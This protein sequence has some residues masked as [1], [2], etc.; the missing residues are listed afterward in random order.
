[1]RGLLKCLLSV[2]LAVVLVARPSAVAQWAV[3]QLPT[4]TG[5]DSSNAWDINDRGQV[6]GGSTDASGGYRAVLWD[7]HSTVIDLGTLPGG[8]DSVATAINNA[9]Q[10]VGLSAVV[11]PGGV[12]YHAFLW[13]DGTMTDLGTPAD[14][15]ASYAW[16]INERGDIVGAIITWNNEWRAA[17]W[18]DGVLGYLGLPPG[19]ISGQAFAINNRGQIAGEVVFPDDARHAVLWDRESVTDIG[20]LP[21]SVGNYATARDVNNRGQVLVEGITA[22]GSAGGYLWNAGS[23]TQ[24]VPLVSLPTF[25]GHV[26]PTA[27]NDRGQ[28]VGGSPVPDPNDATLAFVHAALWD[29]GAVTDLGAL[30]P[31][32]STI[33]RSIN[34]RGQVVGDKYDFRPPLEPTRALLWTR[35]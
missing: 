16:D 8:R 21:G 34:N 35:R 1:M 28:T 11:T 3:I 12:D 33:A 13:Q 31:G 15:R 9:G 6:V 18:R 22:V 29:R 27:L 24:L 30:V 10:V 25:T 2:V 5:G 19:A 23:W 32:H 26:T 17:L 4:L 20:L 14:A 7:H